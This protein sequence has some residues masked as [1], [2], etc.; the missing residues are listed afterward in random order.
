MSCRV[1]NLEVK[2]STNKIRV[3]ITDNFDVECASFLL[4][5]TL[6]HFNG[7]YLYFA[8]QTSEDSS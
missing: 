4:A 5:Q 8:R 3:L 6:K 1:F 2:V 7:L